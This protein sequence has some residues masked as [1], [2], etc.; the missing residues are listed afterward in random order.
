MSDEYES[1]E[2]E[3]EEVEEESEEE[4]APKKKKREKKFKVSDLFYERVH[5]AGDRFANRNACC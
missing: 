2:E 4:E 3:V 5:G 1:V